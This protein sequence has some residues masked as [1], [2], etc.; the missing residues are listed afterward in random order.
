[1]DPHLAAGSSWGRIPTAADVHGSSSFVST[2]GVGQ[3]LI[4]LIGAPG[5]VS[6]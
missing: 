2:R 1:M 5:V 4:L 3:R 6:W